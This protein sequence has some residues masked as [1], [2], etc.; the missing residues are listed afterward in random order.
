M[1]IIARED[2]KQVKRKGFIVVTRCVC[3]HSNGAMKTKKK[4]RANNIYV[5]VWNYWKKNSFSWPNEFNEKKNSFKKKTDTHTHAIYTIIEIQSSI[6]ISGNKNDRNEMIIKWNKQHIYLLLLLLV[7]D[8]TCFT[9]N[10]M[11]I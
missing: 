9:T 4:S 6:N 7:F 3:V 2:N 1:I 11:K 5:C 8:T 10:L